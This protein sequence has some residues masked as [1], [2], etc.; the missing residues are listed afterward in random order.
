MENQPDGY[1]TCGDDLVCH[2]GGTCVTSLFFSDDGTSTE[3]KHCDCSTAVTENT[4]FAGKMCE[5]EATKF[6]SKPLDGMG[7]ESTY[8]CVND[9]E[10]NPTDVRQG[11]TCKDGWTGFRCEF[12]EEASEILDDNTSNTNEEACGD[13]TCFNG[14]KCETIQTVDVDTGTSSTVYVCDCAGATDGSNF[15][16]GPQ[17]EYKSSDICSQQNPAGLF[18]VNN[19]KCNGSDGCDCPSGWTGNM[20]DVIVKDD[21]HADQGEKCGDGYCY[22]NG[23][24]VQTQIKMEGGNTV[25]EYHCDCSSAF[26]DKHRY[27]GI[28]CEHASTSFCSRSNQGDS[29]ASVVF[30]S[31]GGVCDDENPDRGC[32]CPPGWTGLACEFADEPD[33]EADDTGN[34]NAEPQACGDDLACLNGGVCVTTSITDASG[35]KKDMKHCDCASAFTD[36]DTFAG[37]QCEYKQTTFCSAPAQ[38][39]DLSTVQY[40]TNNGVCRENILSGCDCPDAFFGFRCE[41]PKDADELVDKAD[42]PVI[43]DEYVEC[44]DD[45]CYNGSE[46]ETF[47]LGNGQTDYRCNCDT[48]ATSTTLYAGKHCQYASTSLCTKDTLDSLNTADFCVNNGQCPEGDDDKGCSCPSGYT[49]YRCDEPIYEDEDNEDNIIPNDPDE[50]DDG[51]EFYRCKLQCQNDGVC[52]KGAKDLAPFDD[53]V[54][55]VAHLN[56]TY[57]EQYFEHCVCK[58]GWFGLECEHKAEI[59][60]ADEHLCLH[61]STCVKNNQQHGCD[62]SQADETL[63]ANN[64]P[65]FAGESCQHP[66]TDICTY[67][68]NVPGRPLF[69]CT[70][71]GRCNDYVSPSDPDPGCACP[72]EWTGPHCEMR[73]DDAPKLVTT[74]P[75]NSNIMMSIAIFCL[76]AG[77]IVFAYIFMNKRPRDQSSTCMPFRRRK[78][79]SGYDPTDESNNIAPRRSAFSTPDMNPPPSRTFALRSGSSDPMSAFQLDPDDEPEQFRDEP[80]TPY[81]DEPTSGY[82]DTPFQDDPDDEPDSPVLVDVGPSR[83]EDGN[84]LSNVDFI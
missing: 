43:V 51:N 41:Y 68:N 84:Q 59:C 63:G 60:G 53:E 32:K 38:G 25:T 82:H 37:A 12:P 74:N 29:L 30:C 76:I 52:A 66:A 21:Q 31:N 61:G 48:A 36:T 22:N 14:G 2:N 75:P 15:F 4:A 44:G 33:E 8:F 35:Q 69:F 17:C 72:P 55:G 77:T 83:D 3:S 81:R 62:C 5:Y 71:Q 80:R 10:C 57:D 20:C 79:H 9:S 73:V 19:G 65:L 18:C 45:Y 11:C 56:Q 49:G 67:G 78:N 13:L 39:E 24:C 58:E 26:D 50:R 6:C 70:N 64:T 27:G 47:V 7:L 54:E 16:A 28:S 23:Q 34:D 42:D 1:E 40:C 46:C